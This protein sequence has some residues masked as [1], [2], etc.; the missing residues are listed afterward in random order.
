MAWQIKAFAVHA[1]EWVQI[2]RASELGVVMNVSIILAYRGREVGTRDHWNTSLT[3]GWEM[4]PDSRKYIYRVIYTFGHAHTYTYTFMHT[5]TE[6][7][8]AVVLGNSLNLGQFPGRVVAWY[9]HS[10]HWKRKRK[11]R[12]TPSPSRWWQGWAEGPQFL[13]PCFG[14]LPNPRKQQRLYGQR[15]CWKRKLL[16][17]SLD[18]LNQTLWGERQWFCFSASWPAIFTHTG[19]WEPQR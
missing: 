19:G 16:D 12:P 7:Q 6:A 13:C 10:Q 1:W 17:S 3:L 2:L 15:I 11:N 4:G 18:F 5:R 14:V 9:V 8:K